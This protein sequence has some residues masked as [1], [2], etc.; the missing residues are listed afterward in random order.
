MQDLKNGIYS[1]KRIEANI[2][3]DDQEV[4]LPG[5]EISL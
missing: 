3:F 2:I 4:S 1:T 5:I